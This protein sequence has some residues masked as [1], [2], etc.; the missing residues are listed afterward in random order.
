[1]ELHMHSHRLERR[2]PNWPAA[3]ASGFVAGAVVMVVEL[4]WSTLVLG[5]SPWGASHM[6]AGILLGR[7]VIQTTDF[8][9]GIVGVAL[10]THYVLGILFGLVLAII[11]AAFHLDSSAAMTLTTGAVFGVVLY[12]FNFYGF[13][14]AFPWFMEMRSWSTLLAHIIFGMVAAIL[15]WQLEGHGLD[16]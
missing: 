9:V 3:A 2:M 16:R 10:I 4:L 7:D 14:Q 13:A 11:I 8:S 12:L 15:Y 1:M 6:V 5:T